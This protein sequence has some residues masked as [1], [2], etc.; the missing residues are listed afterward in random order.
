METVSVAPCCTDVHGRVSPTDG[1]NQIILFFPSVYV[2]VS[3][4]FVLSTSLPCFRFF[5]LKW[6]ILRN[7]FLWCM[8]VN[9][10]GM[11]RART[12]TTGT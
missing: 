2:S 3:C 8:N 5:I 7:W 11:Y 4:S 6:L 1:Q 10:C 9:H 12:T